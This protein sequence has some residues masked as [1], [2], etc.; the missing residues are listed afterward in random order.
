VQKESLLNARLWL[1]FALMLFVSG[2]SNTFPV[3]FP[4]LL[5]EFRGSRAATAA[6]VSLIWVGGALVGAPAGYLV[7]R[8][9][10]RWVVIAGIWAMALGL[11]LGTIAPGL[12]VFIAVVGCLGGI[13]VGMTGMVTQ[14]ALLAD[15]YVRRRGLANGIA[16]SGSMAG[17]LVALP[18]QMVITR[19]G[20]RG[21]FAGYV[22]I[23]LALVPLAWRILP[24]RLASSASPGEAGQ[25]PG[26]T[27]RG[28]VAR[29][30]FWVLGLL[31]LTPP[32]VAYLATMQHALY[33]RA[34]G[35]SADEASAML[36]VGGALSTSGRVLAGLATDRFG[37]PAAGMLSFLLSLVGLGYL[38]GMEAWPSRLVAYLSVFFVFLPIG[39]RATIVSVLVSRIAPRRH[40]GPI[41]GLLGIGNS[42]G[43]GLGPILSG[44][45]YDRTHSYA[46][47]YVTAT[48]LLLVGLTALI[49]F[50][51]MTRP[52]GAP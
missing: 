5:D 52:R 23:L 41:F 27:I 13:G 34:R 24:T 7:A 43:A 37:A 28:I 36:T 25:E 15:T 1:A 9:N 11:T 31:F 10:P 32:L 6:T 20:W 14:A 47:I 49:A 2:F 46:A 39:S 21:A 8:Y 48:G 50:V 33:F 38:L 16:F 42:V 17:Y 19:W 22:I 12:G 45:I 51:A 30:A 3:F 44:A 18:A 29:P 35:F 26:T 40:Y 4:P